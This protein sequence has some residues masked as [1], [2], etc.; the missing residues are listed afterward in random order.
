MLNSVIIAGGVPKQGDLLYEYT[1]GKPKAL[2]DI[3]GKPMLQ[4]MVDAFTRAQHLGKM[5][6]VG[7]KPED[8]ISSPDILTYVPD[9]GS[10]LGNIIAGIDRMVELIPQ[11]EYILTSTADIPTIT[12]EIVDTFISHWNTVRQQ[13]P[14]DIY[15]HIVPRVLME[16][17]FPGANRSYL[18]VIEGDFAGADMHILAPS[19]AHTH[20][21]LWLNLLNDR[22]N[23]LKQAAR[24]G[25]DFF[26]KLFTHR[27][28]IADVERRIPER[29]GLRVKAI[30]VAHA[31][32]GMDVDKPF[33][34]EICR[35]DLLQ[36]G[37][38]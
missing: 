21:D 22:K 38:A 4:W 11:T 6:I 10:L 28:G 3:A 19:V 14:A 37:R 13:T 31:E 35:E 15:Y 1:Q 12:P 17:R 24:L 23:A 9:Q 34:L 26:L 2:I 25:G 36:Q 8:D 27:L 29:L 32:L 20:Y 16:T 30:P 33:Q 5:V 18:H 7:L